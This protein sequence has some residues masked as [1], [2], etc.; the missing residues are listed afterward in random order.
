MENGPFEVV[1]PIKNGDIPASY[2]SLPE[3]NWSYGPLFITGIRGQPCGNYG[4]I[5]M[6]GPEIQTV[7][8]AFLNEGP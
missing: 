2:V 5:L 6:Q 7:E 1:S 3:G 8:T 4:P